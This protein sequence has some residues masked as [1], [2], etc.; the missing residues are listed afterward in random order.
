MY[1]WVSTR[2][3]AETVYVFSGLRFSTFR[4][5]LGGGGRVEE[6]IERGLTSGGVQWSTAC[7]V[8]KIM[9]K[10]TYYPR[11]WLLPVLGSGLLEESARFF[12]I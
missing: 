7:Y 1:S 9:L 3:C 8:I 6:V 10:L 5:T 4:V 2:R 12:I 11:C